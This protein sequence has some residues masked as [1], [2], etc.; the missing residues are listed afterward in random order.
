ME[1][2]NRDIIEALQTV[3]KVEE[4]VNNNVTMLA[5]HKRESKENYKELKAIVQNSL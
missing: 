5:E 4:R 1:I 2:E 3:G